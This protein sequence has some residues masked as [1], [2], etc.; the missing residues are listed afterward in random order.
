MQHGHLLLFLG[1]S[2]SH[3]T[4]HGFLVFQ[5]VFL[6]V[7]RSQ[8]YSTKM[9]ECHFIGDQEAR[10]CNRK[11][12]FFHEITDLWAKSLTVYLICDKGE[13][14][15]RKEYRITQINKDYY[16]A[17]ES[18]NKVSYFVS[19][20]I[21]STVALHC[22]RQRIFKNLFSKSKNKQK[23]K[24]IRNYPDKSA[25]LTTWL[26]LSTR[27]FGFSLS[28]SDTWLVGAAFVLAALRNVML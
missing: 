13:H 20:K 3:G 5:H 24:I 4:S 10:Y 16:F 1:S 27:W 28:P 23:K 11:V 14:K 18:I 25:V 19:Y 6:F 8:T 15:A 17:R 21:Q 22:G 9:A 26:F 7:Y 2:T 12:Q